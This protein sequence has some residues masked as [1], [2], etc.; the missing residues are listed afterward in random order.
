MRNNYLTNS[1]T[2]EILF[3]YVDRRKNRNNFAPKKTTNEKRKKT[4]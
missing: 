2:E 4:I 1:K 3:Q